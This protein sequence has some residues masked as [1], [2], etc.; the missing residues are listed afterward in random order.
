MAHSDPQ[1]HLYQ[2]QQKR[3]SDWIVQWFC[4]RRNITLRDLTQHPCWSDLVLLCHIYHEFS[5]VLASSKT[6]KGVFDGYWGVVYTGK[7]RLKPKALKRL[8]QL[9]LNCISQQQ[10]LN[11]QRQQIKSM[12]ASGHT[13]N[14]DHDMTAKGS[15]LPAEVSTREPQGGREELFLSLPWL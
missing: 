7:H 3:D 2:Q 8:E 14:T 5:P 11:Q 12:R 4:R 6:L 13:Q 9:T 10:I 1:S 15:N